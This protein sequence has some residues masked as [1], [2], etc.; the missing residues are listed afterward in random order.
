MAVVIRLQRAG[1]RNRP[2]YRVVVADSRRARDGAFI[3]KVGYYDPIPD[4]DVI[5]LDHARV[6][7]WIGKGAQPSEAVR[8]LIRRSAKRMAA[9]APLAA[10][11]GAAAVPKP[12]EAPPEAAGPEPAASAGVEAGTGDAPGEETSPEV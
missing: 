7:G 3:E 12:V 11:A 6:S 9:G 10:P 5:S 2:F 1:A 4:P 8:H